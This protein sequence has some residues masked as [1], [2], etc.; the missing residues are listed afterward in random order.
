VEGLGGQERGAVSELTSI[1]GRRL[2]LCI[3]GSSLLLGG[4]GGG[5]VLRTLEVKSAPAGATVYLD[6]RPVGRTPCTVEYDFHGTR[7]LRVALEGYRP[8]Q[9]EVDLT[10]HWWQWFPLDFCTEVLWPFTIDDHRTVEVTLEQ[11]EPG[12]GDT[13]ATAEF[14]ARAERRLLDARVRG[15][16]RAIT[17]QLAELAALIEREPAKAA[18]RALIART[19]RLREALAALPR[20]AGSVAALA[21]WEASHRAAVRNG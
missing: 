7:A 17:E 12:P 14:T 8:H 18:R 1:A 11:I 3:L 16:H 9:G 5:C 2:A 13:A 19:D 4:G 6:D 21:G 15:Y 10:A 20:R